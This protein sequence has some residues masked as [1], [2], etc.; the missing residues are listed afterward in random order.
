M[1]KTC[2]ERAGLA[3]QRSFVRASLSNF[4]LNGHPLSQSLRCILHVAAEG[5]GI[6]IFLKHSL[7]PVPNLDSMRVVP[8]PVPGSAS[9]G[10]FVLRVPYQN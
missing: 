7:G 5:S 1:C 10:K 3:K 6:P 9:S 8:F 2:A 4:D